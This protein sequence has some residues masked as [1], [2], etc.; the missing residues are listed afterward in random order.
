ML[1]QEATPAFTTLQNATVPVKKTGPIR[2]KIVL[3]FLFLGFLATSA[4]VFHKEDDLKP[5]LSLGS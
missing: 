5:L 3:I 1:V 4:W 2:S